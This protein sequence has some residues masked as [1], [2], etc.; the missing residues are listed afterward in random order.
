LLHCLTKEMAKV[1]DIVSEICTWIGTT[2]GLP[3][4]PYGPEWVEMTEVFQK[5]V[6]ELGFCT[7]DGSPVL[8]MGYNSL[9]A[10]IR[11]MV[12]TWYNTPYVWDAL[13][14]F[15]G[16]SEYQGMFERDPARLRK[17]VVWMYFLEV[18]TAYIEVHPVFG[19]TQALSWKKS[20]GTSLSTETGPYT[21]LFGTIKTQSLFFSVDVPVDDDHSG[22]SVLVNITEAVLKDCLLGNTTNAS[23][24][25]I[26]LQDMRNI[27][28]QNGTSQ[29]VGDMDLSVSWV[30]LYMVWNMAFVCYYGAP[31][32][33][34]KLFIPSTLDS[35]HPRWLERRIST[36][37]MT[38]LSR[39]FRECKPNWNVKPLHTHFALQA[40]VLSKRHLYHPK[41]AG[42]VKSTIL[43]SLSW[44]FDKL[45]VVIAWVEYML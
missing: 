17:I 45:T 19:E 39:S 2:S 20:T 7:D 15:H 21:T 24:G 28:R 29:L 27:S 8:L 1:S 12:S 34:C 41:D 6:S 4:Q 30:Q 11:E 44:L 31:E 26:L 43:S 32:I 14:T 23:N 13:S 40:S 3:D 18:S 9:T 37:R 36:L 25:R 38:A 42:V 16:W 35:N 33:F 22:V 10:F 5:H